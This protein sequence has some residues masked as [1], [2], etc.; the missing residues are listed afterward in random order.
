MFIFSISRKVYN[1]DIV[2]CIVHQIYEIYYSVTA[3]R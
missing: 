3:K 2:E 1:I